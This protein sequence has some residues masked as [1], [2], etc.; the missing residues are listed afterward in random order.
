VRFFYAG[1]AVF[2]K[3]D[4]FEP[5]KDPLFSDILVTI[6]KVWRQE[7]FDGIRN[8]LYNMPIYILFDPN[9]GILEYLKYLLYLLPAYVIGLSFHEAAH[10]WM[11]NRMGDPTAKNLGRLTLDPTKHINLFG[12]ISF[13]IIGF[14]WA[15]PVP[16]NPRNFG[17]YKKGNI[18]VSLAGITMN[19]IISFVFYGIVILLYNGFGIYNEILIQIL[20]YIVM[21][22]LVL[23]FFNLIPIPPLDG[24]HLISGFIARKSPKFYFYYMRYGNIALLLLVFWGYLQIVISFGVNGVLWLYAKFFGL[25]L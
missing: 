18:L 1:T 8:F 9:G 2:Y 15:K 5:L 21:M 7:M 19:L 24:H 25:F 22:N 13:F 23:C 14:G 20:Y 4:I 11:A 3:F 12:V 6:T 17:N 16:I 10:A